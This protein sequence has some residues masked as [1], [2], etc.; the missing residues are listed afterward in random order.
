MCDMN[1]RAA[2]QP[3]V[4]A[5][6]SIPPRLV[7]IEISRELVGLAEQE[8]NLSHQGQHWFSEI[9]WLCGLGSILGV[10]G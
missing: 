2:I 6:G 3:I 5:V 10:L 1:F 8:A 4:P 9:L 7:V